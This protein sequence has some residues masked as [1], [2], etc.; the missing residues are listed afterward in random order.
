MS[1]VKSVL[2]V[3]LGLLLTGLN[4]IVVITLMLNIILVFFIT[5]YLGLIKIIK[6]PIER[7]FG[8]EL[9]WW[10]PFEQQVV[11]TPVVELLKE[12]INGFGK[13][14]KWVVSAC[15]NQ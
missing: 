1:Y 11:L 13:I 12:S 7:L 8:T 14:W 10:L 6:N 9:P 4:I 5:G 3:L 15:K 2:A